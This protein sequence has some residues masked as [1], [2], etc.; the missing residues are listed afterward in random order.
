MRSLSLV[1]GL[2]L[3]CTGPVAAIV[4][5][6]GSPCSNSCG[7][8]LDATTT[9]D[10]V[11]SDGDYATN[12]TG[13]LFKQCADCEM[14]SNYYRNENDTDMGA[15][16]C[17]LFFFFTYNLRYTLSHCFFGISSDDVLQDNPCLTRTSCGDFRPGTVYKNLSTD[18]GPYEYCDV[19]PADEFDNFNQCKACLD[20]YEKPFLSNFITALQAGC[21]QKPVPGVSVALHGNI[22]SDTNVTVASPTPQVS[23]DP[24][25]FDQGPITSGAIAGIVAAGIVVSLVLA[26]CFIVWRGKRRRRTFLENYN[27]S[28]S[29]SAVSKN[30]RGK[31]WPSPL[32]IQGMKDM[33][34]DTPLSQRPLRTWD[35]S[36]Q[37]AFSD[38]QFP[39]YFSPYSSQYTSPVSASDQQQHHPMHSWPVLGGYRDSPPVPQPAPTTS[40]QDPPASPRRSIGLAIGAASPV[41]TGARST[42][43][44]AVTESYELQ[45]VDGGAAD[46]PPSQRGRLHSPTHSAGSFR[47]FSARLSGDAA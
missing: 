44:E 21:E 35:D 12:T 42:E 34:S 23:V 39:R 37:S 10:I 20:T 24:S 41:D 38:Q 33:S 28:L 6:D 43:T 9:S 46:T 1:A 25:W 18:V 26:G 45:P 8:V 4:V 14:T 17:M 15:A 27:K 3:V 31:G 2:T 7:N 32:Q 40:H 30:P 47:N 22:F 36:P 11:C 29:T 5:A 16:L 13:Q 19:W